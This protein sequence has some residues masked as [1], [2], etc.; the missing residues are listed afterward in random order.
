MGVARRSL[1][2]RLRKDKISEMKFSFRYPTRFLPMVY[3]QA[4]R[5][6]CKDEAGLIVT[7]TMDYM[8]GEIIVKIKASKALQLLR[9]ASNILA[10]MAL[11][12]YG[13]DMIELHED[14]PSIGKIR[15][16]KKYYDF[17]I[18]YCETKKDFYLELKGDE[19][20]LVIYYKQFYERYG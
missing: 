18:A 7:I 4:V 11:A 15:K 8:K 19:K 3:G 14:E 16:G 1:M 9:T 17:D 2:W 10:F 12:E 5:Q 13:C 6:F 20:N